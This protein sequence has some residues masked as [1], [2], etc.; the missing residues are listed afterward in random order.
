MFILS[1]LMLLT[2][3]L[4]IKLLLITLTEFIVLTLLTMLAIWLTLVTNTGALTIVFW[5]I[6]LLY[7]C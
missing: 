3:A 4:L 1:V 2:Y 5:I 7:S 6:A